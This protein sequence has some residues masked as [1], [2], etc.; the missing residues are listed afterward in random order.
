MLLWEDLCLRLRMHEA[1]VRGT[2]L[3]KNCQRYAKKKAFNVSVIHREK[4]DLG[5]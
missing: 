2:V 1:I 4:E 5:V 3:S